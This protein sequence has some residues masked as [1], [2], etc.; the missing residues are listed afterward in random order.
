MDDVTWPRASTSQSLI[1]IAL[2]HGVG[3]SHAHRALTDCDILARLLER[4]A[5]THDVEAM[6]VKA[7]RPKK[8]YRAMVSFDT[9]QLAKERG[10][11]WSPEEKIWWRKFVPEDVPGL[12]LPFELQEVDG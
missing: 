12:Q 10:F 9:N 11:R 8:K 4:V 2:A 1:A 5:E 3:V 6:L 7:M